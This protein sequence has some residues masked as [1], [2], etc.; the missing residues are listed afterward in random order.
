MTDP[1]RR[2]FS[3]AQFALG[4]ATLTR[5]GDVVGTLT[6]DGS[7][8]PPPWVVRVLGLRQV[9]QGTVGILRPTPSMAAWGAAVDASH[10]ASLVPLMVF[11]PRYRAAAVASSGLAAAAALLGWSMSR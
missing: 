5:P 7:A 9:V 2:A 10:A 1:T 8:A 4:V 11:S 3:A 6:P